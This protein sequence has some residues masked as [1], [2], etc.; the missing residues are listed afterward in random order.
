MWFRGS[1]VHFSPDVIKVMRLVCGE[2]DLEILSLLFAQ[3]R[4]TGRGIPSM[5]QAHDPDLFYY[6]LLF[7]QNTDTL[8]LTNTTNSLNLFGLVHTIVKSP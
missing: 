7:F 3:E 4:D 8:D 6:K 5:K 2:P 1:S